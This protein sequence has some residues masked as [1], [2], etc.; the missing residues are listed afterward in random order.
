MQFSSAT[1]TCLCNLCNVGQGE[2]GKTA[3]QALTVAKGF[4]QFDDKPKKT[5]EGKQ[6]I[7]I[8][9]YRNYKKTESKWNENKDERGVLPKKN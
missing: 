8:K 2:K 9:Q 3:S 7:K 1:M 6:K 5:D 4:R